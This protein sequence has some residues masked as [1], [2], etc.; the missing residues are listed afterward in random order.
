MP[1]LRILILTLTAINAAL[2]WHAFYFCIFEEIV[3]K[4]DWIIRCCKWYILCS[5]LLLSG[6]V[7]ARPLSLY[8]LTLGEKL[9]LPECSP[10]AR[11][12]D[13][14]KTCIQ[15]S[16]FHQTFGTVNARGGSVFYPWNSP[17]GIATHD[18]VDVFV[19]EQGR[20]LWLRFRT[21]GVA[22]QEKV[23][24]ELIAQFGE[25]TERLHARDLLQYGLPIG[26]ESLFA[27]WERDDARITFIGQ[28]RSGRL[29]SVMLTDRRIIPDE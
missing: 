4:S 27:I 12:E 6:F 13:I 9:D 1:L 7:H 24:S 14:Q 21:N 19:D 15:N 17:P 10:M 28:S 26:P 25:P 29:G 2:P 3:L 5:I 22:T 11:M 23:L 16:M 8:G 20:L 18:P